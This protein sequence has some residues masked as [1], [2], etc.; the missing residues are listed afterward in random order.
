M[1]AGGKLALATGRRRRLQPGRCRGCTSSTTGA[2]PGSTAS[3]GAAERERR[4]AARRRRLARGGAAEPRRHRRRTSGPGPVAIRADGRARRRR[5]RRRR[6]RSGDLGATDPARAPRG[7]RRRP[8]LRRRRQRW[9]AAP[10]SRGRRAGRRRGGRARHRGA[11]RRGRGARAWSP[12]HD[13]GTIS[14]WEPGAAEPLAAWPSPVAGATA[15]RRVGRRRAGRARLARRAPSPSPA[16]VG[17]R[18]RDRA[19]ASRAP[20]SSPRRPPATALLVAGDWGCAWLTPTRGGRMSTRPLPPPEVLRDDPGPWSVVSSVFS[21]AGRPGQAPPPAA[22]GPHALA[23]ARDLPRARRPRP[24]VARGR[25]RAACAWWRPRASPPCTWPSR[26]AASLRGVSPYVDPRLVAA[27]PRRGL[28]GA[29]GR[30][31]G[32]RAAAAGR[33]GG[34]RPATCRRRHRPRR[35]RRRGPHARGP[36]RRGRAHPAL[37][38]RAGA[39]G[40]RRAGG[41]VVGRRRAPSRSAARGACCWRRPR[42]RA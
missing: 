23:A 36:P 14:V 31:P 32:R 17:A 9:L 26:A 25:R 18:R 7:R 20:A 28:R 22:D 39:L 21:Q 10:E 11:G 30:R 24:L 29:P 35:R 34:L 4:P 5:G 12:R 38:P 8:L 27:R 42:G 13:D 3:L 6:W 15:A 37:R 41:G 2:R 33:A 1:V 19:R 16:C 40:A